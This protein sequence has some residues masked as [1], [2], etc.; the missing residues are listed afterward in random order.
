MNSRAVPVLLLLGT[1][2]AGCGGDDGAGDES[3]GPKDATETNV[4]RCTDDDRTNDDGCDAGATVL[5]DGGV[6]DC[7]SALDCPP[8]APV[9]NSH[10]LCAPNFLHQE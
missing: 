10:H 3:H 6:I 9:C 4:F 2:A 7:D 5:S 1:L 8:E